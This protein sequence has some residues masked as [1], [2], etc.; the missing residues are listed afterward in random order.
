MRWV[1]RGKRKILLRVLPCF[2]LYSRAEGAVFF[3]LLLSTESPCSAEPCVGFSD[4][5]CKTPVL[6]F[7]LV[8]VS[9]C[10]LPTAGI[11]AVKD[12]WGNS[13]HTWVTDRVLWL[14][15]TFTWCLVVQQW[16]LEFSNQL[17]GRPASWIKPRLTASRF[18]WRTPIWVGGVGCCVALCA[19]LEHVFALVSSDCSVL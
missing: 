7:L 14:C 5:C 4:F 18:H 6:H 8:T 15:N 9:Q 3:P 13:E 1:I 2:F 11:S 17:I 10:S 16:W 12:V 19:G